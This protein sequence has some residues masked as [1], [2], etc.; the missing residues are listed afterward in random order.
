MHVVT[1][2][3]SRVVN[4]AYKYLLLRSSVCVCIHNGASHNIYYDWGLALIVTLRTIIV[5]AF[6]SADVFRSLLMLVV[7]CQDY[8][9]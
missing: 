7:G 5:M 8:I 4:A 9:Y 6:E 3:A 2:R 1:T